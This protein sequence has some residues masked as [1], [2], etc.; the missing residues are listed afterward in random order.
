MALDPTVFVHPRGLCESDEVGPRTRIWAFA[1]VMKG[2]KVGSDCNVCDHAFIETG[3]SVGNHVTI[4]NAVQ[5]WD[6]VTIEDEVFLGPNM[7]FT[8]DINPRVAFKNS[9]DKF[10]TTRVERGVSIGA[11]AT[12]VCGITLGTNAFV[13]AG[14]VVIRDVPAYALMVGNPARQIGWMCA[15]AHKLPESL[16]CNECGRQYQKSG[17]LG[18]KLVGGP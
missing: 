1:H 15:C 17:A 2:A 12:I 14:A 6:K 7:I 13:G 4:K 9:P 11:N 16:R 10:L 8:N 5:I 3:A 18:L